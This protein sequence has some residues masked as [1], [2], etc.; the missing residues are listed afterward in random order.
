MELVNVIETLY[1]DFGI[2]ECLK[3]A[4]GLQKGDSAE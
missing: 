1:T 3:R 2:R 4:R